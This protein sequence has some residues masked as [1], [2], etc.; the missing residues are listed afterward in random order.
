MDRR[1][2]LVDDNGDCL[3]GREFP[4]LTQV[5]AQLE[6]LRTLGSYRRAQ[7]GGVLFGQ[8][9][10]PRTLGTIRLGDVLTVNDSI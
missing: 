9:L 8:N 2:M 7:D 10:I 1:W 4:I 6:P 3:A 5:R